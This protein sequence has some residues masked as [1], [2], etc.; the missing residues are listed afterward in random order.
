MTAMGRVFLS[1]VAID[2]VL[3]LVLLLTTLQASG[4]NDGGREMAVAFYIVLPALV[5]GLAILLQVFCTHPVARGLALLVVAA[6]GLALA[7]AQLRHV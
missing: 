4:Q 1:V 5:M 3:L 7:A 6:P 2:T